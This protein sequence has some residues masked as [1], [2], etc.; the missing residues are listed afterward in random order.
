MLLQRACRNGLIG[1]ST[2]IIVFLNGISS[3][4]VLGQRMINK[5]PNQEFIGARPMALGETFVAVA[6]DI[7]ASYWNPAGLAALPMFGISSMH[8]NLFQSDIGMNYL[9]LGIP[10]PRKIGF[11]LDWL[12]IGAMDNELDFRKNKFNFSIGCPLMEGLAMGLNVKR[13]QM[14]TALDNIS[15]GSFHGWGVDVGLLYRPLPRWNLGMTIHDVTNT[16]LSGIDQPVYRRNVRIGAAYQ[17]SNQLLIASDIDDRLHLGAEWW[18]L[19]QWVVFRAGVQR[20][21]YTDEPATLS[22]GFGLDLPLWGQRLRLDYAYTDSPSLL[23]THRTSLSLA[24]DPF[25]RLVKIKQ[26]EIGPVFASL[27]KY[28]QQHPIGQLEL[29]YKGKSDLECTILVSVAKY[30]FLYR[31]NI[32]IPGHSMAKNVQTININCPFSDAIMNEFDDIPLM[33]DIKISYLTGNRIKTESAS[34]TFPL[35][36][37]NRIDWQYGVEQ[38]AAFIT[39]EDPAIIQFARQACHSE[40]SLPQPFFVNDGMTRAIEL[41]EAASSF[42]IRFEADTYSPYQLACRS[43]DNLFYPAQLWIQKR[44][45]CDD[46]V[47]FFAALFENQNIPTAL[48]SVPG[49]LL[50]MFDS[51]IHPRQAFRLC[52]AED[53]YMEYQGRLWIPLETTLVDHGFQKAWRAGAAQVRKFADQSEIV[54]VRDAWRIYQP[55]TEA[56]V[57]VKSLPVFPCQSIA[58]TIDSL[59]LMQQQHLNNL[60]ELLARSPDNSLLRNQLAVRYAIVGDLD[61]AEQYFRYLIARDSLEKRALNN[62][63][64]VWMMRGQ[65]DSAF[66]YYHRAFVSEA[67]E[68]NDGVLLNLGLLYSAAGQDST[69]AE[70][71]AQVMRHED[72]YQRIGQLLGIAILEEDL[73][74]ASNLQ[75]SKKV[76]KNTVNRLIREAR[77]KKALAKPLKKE[78]KKTVGVKG[79]FPKEQ[80]ENIFY[81][82]F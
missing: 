35:Y 25:P 39:P 29:E 46:L 72:D 56:G 52:C 20:D 69:A 62:F 77:A 42:G 1:I 50:L 66:V 26:V 12:S 4:S 75:P 37:R 21:F 38:A 51:G 65:L 32:V 2:I 36:R 64:N 16:R 31:K 41:F 78:T 15:Q 73:A 11:A 34:R 63:G 13:V 47:V 3:K 24:I 60:E 45:D 59:K 27:Y 14:S 53:C 8:C 79:S 71:F 57:L 55:I 74:K 76:D 48:V 43:L 70:L 82:A 10:G 33:A 22:M 61:R 44:G 5:I 17:V 81:W 80:M 18:P 9:S 7:N 54:I 68:M 19:N 30:G 23:N 49:H 6:N 28:Y 40:P 58:E 67:N